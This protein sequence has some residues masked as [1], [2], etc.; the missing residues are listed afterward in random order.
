MC[1]HSRIGLHEEGGGTKAVMEIMIRKKDVFKLF[2]RPI[3]VAFRQQYT[4]FRLE[5]IINVYSP[6]SK[7]SQDICFPLKHI[8]DGIM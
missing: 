8:F 1:R 3:P 2:D 4:D 7:L 6:L 5:H